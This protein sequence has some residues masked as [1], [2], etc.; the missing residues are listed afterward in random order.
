MR[1]ADLEDL[2]NRQFEAEQDIERLKGEMEDAHS[3]LREL[4]E[5]IIPAAMDAIGMATFTS[6]SGITIEVDTKIHCRKVTNLAALQWL[7][8]NKQSGSIKSDVVAAF[9]KGDKEAAESL[10]DQLSDA[11]YSCKMDEHVNAQTAG[12]LL[13][14]L[15]AAGVNVPLELF[16]AHQRTASKI[17]LVGKKK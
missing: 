2:A 6:K 13:T 1:L 8:D 15:M 10:I 5:T 14:R 12:A 3:S 7:I 4:C 17:T 9:S 11:G 16:G